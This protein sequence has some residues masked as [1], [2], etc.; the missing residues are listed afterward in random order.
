MSVLTIPST[1]TLES[2]PRMIPEQ[3]ITLFKFYMDQSMQDG[4]TYGKELY[5]LAK[6]FVVSDRLEAYRY[7]CELLGQGVPTLISVSKQRY[8]VWTG[9]RRP[10]A[11]PQ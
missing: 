6:Q 10:L 3:Q 11:V 8:I 7:G 1:T 5:R 2:A 9:L 4:V